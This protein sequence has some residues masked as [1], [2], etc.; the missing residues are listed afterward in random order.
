MSLIPYQF[1]QLA[2]VAVYR[3]N[4]YP[5]P[6]SLSVVVAGKADEPSQVKAKPAPASAAVS[7]QTKD[8]A[9]DSFM[10]EMEGLL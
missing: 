10:R 1:N 4:I 6:E 7:V 3:I 2:S 9:Y 8:D 5:I